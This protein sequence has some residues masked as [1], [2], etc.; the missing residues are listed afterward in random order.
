MKGLPRHSSHYS[1]PQRTPGPWYEAKTG[2]HQ[3]LVISEQTGANIAVTYD[4]TD[5]PFI[6]RACNSYDDLLAALKDV[7]A[8]CKFVG[9]AGITAY[10]ISDERMAAVHAAIAKAKA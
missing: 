1:E 7:A 2:N 9:P 6:V 3:G 5:A 10:A 8:C 4:A